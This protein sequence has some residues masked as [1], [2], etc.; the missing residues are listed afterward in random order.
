[1]TYGIIGV[2]GVGGYVVEALVRSGVG[3]LDLIDGSLTLNAAPQP[4]SSAP[5][6]GTAF[7]VTDIEYDG[8]VLGRCIA[9][10]GYQ[11]TSQPTCSVM[12]L[13]A[14]TPYEPLK[15]GFRIS[16]PPRMFMKHRAKK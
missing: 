1:M 2:G 9:P 15:K 5:A 7:A 3:A 4:Q 12:T 16:I 13:G 14:L 8:S 10:V 11:V 6:G